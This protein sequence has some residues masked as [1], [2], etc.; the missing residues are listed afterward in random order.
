[1]CYTKWWHGRNM[2]D[3][4]L[5]GKWLECWGSRFLGYDTAW[6]CN[7]ILMFGRSI[8][9]LSLRVR[10]FLDI[11][12]PVDEDT[13]LPWRCSVLVIQWHCSIC[14]KHGIL[15][16]AAVK[17]LNITLVLLLVAL[18]V[19][20]V[21][22]IFSCPLCMLILSFH[23]LYKLLCTIIEAFVQQTSSWAHQMRCR[24]LP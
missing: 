2:S 5:V 13:V 6:R 16:Y 8:V 10:M 14:Q 9:S 18:L 3:L 15:S 23:W 12:I 1:M 11:S 22:L 17:N 24:H 20:M 21:S 19:V 4:C 7:K